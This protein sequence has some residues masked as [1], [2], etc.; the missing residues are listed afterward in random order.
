MSM[1][2]ISCSSEARIPIVDLRMNQITPDTTKVNTPIDT[3]PR[4]WVP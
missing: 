3:M 1:P 4:I 2:I